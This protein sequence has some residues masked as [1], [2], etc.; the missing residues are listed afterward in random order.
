[1]S[2]GLC[3]RHPRDSSYCWNI[4]ETGAEAGTSPPDENHGSYLVIRRVLISVAFV[5]F[6]FNLKD[7]NSVLSLH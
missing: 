7:Y 2:A 3:A 5:M 4:D 6:N 1:M